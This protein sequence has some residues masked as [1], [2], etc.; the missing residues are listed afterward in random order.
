M[1][2][3]IW[4]F[5]SCINT[6]SVSVYCGSARMPLEIQRIHIGD[7]STVE[8]LNPSVS[9]IHPTEKDSATWQT[10]LKSLPESLR[11]QRVPV[12]EPSALNKRSVMC[13]LTWMRE[14][15]CSPCLVCLMRHLEM[16]CLLVTARSLRFN[17][18]WEGRISLW[19][20]FLA[21]VS[22]TLFSK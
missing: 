20:H 16:F 12:R 13:P 9:D 19:H 11:Y 4:L 22:F 14:A 18:D 7:V 5:I 2:T 1:V 10:C 15:I 17:S 8:V 6:Y 3:I 21:T